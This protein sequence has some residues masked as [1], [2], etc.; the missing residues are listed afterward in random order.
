MQI[1]IITFFVKEKV[2]WRLFLAFNPACAALSHDKTAA[3]YNLQLFCSRSTK[4]YK[5]FGSVLGEKILPHQYGERQT[6]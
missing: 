4:F 2:E 5:I 6:T 1:P 3:A